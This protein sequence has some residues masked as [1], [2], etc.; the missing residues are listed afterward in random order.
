MGI[1]GHWAWKPFPP[2]LVRHGGQSG[3]GRLAARIRG[4]SPEV[5]GAAE[6]ISN[7][8]VRYVSLDNVKRITRPQLKRLTGTEGATTVTAGLSSVCVW[9]GSSAIT[10]EIGS[11]LISELE[12]RLSMGSGLLASTVSTSGALD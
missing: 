3:G 10:G 1:G 7:D 2:S 11:T 5:A 4:V 6:T 12:A 9:E 8:T